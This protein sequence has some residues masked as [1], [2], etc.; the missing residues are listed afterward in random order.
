MIEGRS[1]RARRN[2]SGNDS[3]GGRTGRGE[4]EGMKPYPPYLLRRR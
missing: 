4:G 2:Q 1:H 3:E